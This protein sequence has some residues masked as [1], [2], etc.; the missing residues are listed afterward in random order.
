MGA[1]FSFHYHQTIYINKDTNEVHIELCRCN[2]KGFTRKI[3]LNNSEYI[4][5]IRLVRPNI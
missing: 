3:K 2:K 4:N 1:Y 5:I